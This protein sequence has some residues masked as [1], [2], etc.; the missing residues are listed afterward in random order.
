MR[1]GIGVQRSVGNREQADKLKTIATI[2][3]ESNVDELKPILEKFKNSLIDFAL[4][5]KTKINEDPDFRKKFFDMCSIVGVDPLTSNKGFWSELLGSGDFFINIAV[6]VLTVSLATRAT[7]GGIMELSECVNEINK[8]RGKNASRVSGDDIKVAVDR[9]TSSLGPSLTIYTVGSHSYVSSVPESM[10]SD[11]LIAL[12]CAS[13]NGGVFSFKAKKFQDEKWNVVR[14]NK[15]TDRMQRDGLVWVDIHPQT[16]A[17]EFWF[18][19][20]AMTL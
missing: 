10:G 17:E 9:I 7:N 4:K 20:L 1:R 14:F 11:E 12:E 15:M 3:K 8:L 6:Q 2:A 18:Y 19:S 5:H 13:E 16:K